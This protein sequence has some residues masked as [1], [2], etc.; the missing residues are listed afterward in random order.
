MF[1]HIFKAVSNQIPK[2]QLLRTKKRKSP[3][4]PNNSRTSKSY[5]RF[6]VITVLFFFLSTI[7]YSSI[8]Y[9]N[10]GQEQYI[11]DEY[12]NDIIEENDDF[13]NTIDGFS[14]DKLDFKLEIG[15]ELAPIAPEAGDHEQ[16]LE[17]P[18]SNGIPVLTTRYKDP[19]YLMSNTRGSGPNVINET[20]LLILVKFSDV[21]TTRPVSEL[22]DAVFNNTPSAISVH[23]YYKEVSYGIVNIEPGAQNGAAAGKWLNISSNRTF[24]G[25][26]K[27]SGSYVTDDG[28]SLDGKWWTEGKVQLVKDACN[29]TDAAGVDFKKY[30]NDGPDGVP[31]SADDDGVVDHVL[32]IFSGNGQNHYGRDTTPSPGPDDD[33]GINDYG[34]DLVW[35]SR[36]QYNFG[37]YDGK[38]VFGATVN[39]EDP[40]FNI[41][42][43]VICHEFGHDLGL[44]DLY[45]TDGTTNAVV[46]NWELM[47]SGTYNTNSTGAARPSHP[48]A[49][50]KEQLG[51]IQP[52]IINETNNNQGV[53]RVNQTTSPTNDSVC[54]KVNIIGENEYYL[55]E[56]RN[57]TVGTYEEGLSDRGILIWHID[58]DMNPYGNNRG[59]PTYTYYPILLE[60]YKND[61]NGENYITSMNTAC[62]KSSGAADQ[63][64]F[65]VSTF[66]NS[67]AN[68]G[69]RSGIYIDRIL[70]NSLWNMTVRILVSDDSNLPG[71]PRDVKVYDSENDNGGSINI[72]WNASLD[73]GTGDD[74]VVSYNILINETGSIQNPKRLIRVVD[75]IDAPDYDI[76]ITGLKDGVTYNFTVL[77]DDGPNV[78]PYPGNFTVVPLDNIALPP[79]DV[80]AVDTFPDDG[81]NITITWSLSD[82]DPNSIIPGAKDIIRYNISYGVIISGPK[83]IL[84][85]LGPGNTSFRVENLTNGVKYYFLVTAVDDVL[86]EG[87]SIEVNATPI[88]N[89]IGSPKNIQV[90]PSV[91]SNNSRYLIQWNNP[92]DNSQIAEAFYKIGSP[93]TSND[94]FTGNYSWYGIYWLW[95][96]DL[97]SDGTHTVYIWLKDYENNAD[98][99]TARF[100]TIRHDETPPASVKNL[101]VIPFGWSSS[102]SFTFTWTNPSEVSGVNGVHFTINTPPKS[103]MDGYYRSGLNINT[104]SNINISNKG[105]NTIYIWLMDRAYNSDYKTYTSIDFY[106]DPDEPNRPLNLLAIPSSWTNINS[107]DVTWDNPSEL[108]GIIGAWYKVGSVPTSNNDG[109]YKAG[110]NISRINKIKAQNTGSNIVYVWLV[111]NAT[112]LDY[113]LSNYTFLR[114][115]ALAPDRPV[116]I[117]SLPSFW[118][119]ENRFYINWSLPWEWDQSSIIGVY[120][121]FNN[122]PLHNTDGIFISSLSIKE[123]FNITVPRNG[124]NELYLWLQ[125]EVGNV[126][127]LNRTSF[128]LY[129]DA[130]APDEPN[131]LTPHPTNIW[132]NKNN[133]SVSWTNPDE[134]SGIAGAYYKVNS[135][136]NYN[137]DGIYIQRNWINHI[138]DIKVPKLG[139]NTIY[140]WLVDR[141]GNINYLNHSYVKLLFDD[142]PPGPPINITVTPSKWTRNN[143]FN[144]SWTN[145]EEHSGIYGLYYWFSAP[146]QNIGSL[147]IK[148]GINF[149]PNFKIP[150]DDPPS[151]EYTLYIWLIDNAYNFDFR[152]NNSQELLY[153][154]SA[155]YITHTRVYYATRD[156]PI[157]I[158]TIVDDENS[159]VNEVKIHYKKDTDKDY[160]ELVMARSGSNIYKGEIPSNKVTGNSLSYFISASDNT[161]ISNI[162]YYGKEGQVYYKPDPNSD[163]DIQILDED[164]IPPTIMHQR[165][166]KGI[167][168]TKLA[169][170][171]TVTDD[172]SGVKDVKVFYKI[173]T[174]RN[175]QE[176]N[177][178]NGNPYYYE[179]PESVMTSYGVDYY[180]YAIDNSPKG[181]EIYFGNYGLTTVRP[182]TNDSYI[183]IIVSSL[184]DIAP[185]II[186]GPEV[187]D[188]KSTTANVF[189]ITDEPSDSVIEFDTDTELSNRGFNTSYVTSHSLFLTGLTP[190]TL[191]Y[192]QVS[193]KDRLGNG[194]TFS[195]VFTF[196]TTKVG[197]EDTDGD[198]LPDNVDTDDDNDK[199]PD[200]VF[201]RR[202]AVH[203]FLPL[204]QRTG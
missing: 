96:E 188:V 7:F 120:Y 2:R 166:E 196:R 36:L 28:W 75:A 30:D 160:T 55:V 145:P 95:V 64:D 169:M 175:F 177:M 108:S 182:N 176:A 107:F 92:V 46:G 100:V 5:S 121:K 85:T 84:A 114:Y 59:P 4:N 152:N 185:L 94:D 110:K 172:G 141:V 153:D 23:N 97:L 142:Q 8:Y 33:G 189:W 105:K 140:V 76:Q 129:Y 43:G 52:I 101:A 71:P 14:I 66:P 89:Y 109:T 93:P 102:Y 98:Y 148:D 183:Q 103:E 131:L 184:D 134:Y 144:I 61:A 113:R 60:N 128:T 154:V 57:K 167:V 99:K 136:P 44:P 195:N 104:L 124:T 50:C 127:Y 198:N 178:K 65:N 40:N 32:I 117:Q 126:D 39:P 180:L 42:V 56:N 82:D 47:D 137:T 190:D 192:Y 12:Q 168:G 146:T 174:D 26:D 51:W 68:G 78:S 48:G 123:L 17:K 106:Y 151:D 54:Y 133:F 112:N 164:V 165:I 81:M 35:P 31:N 191:Y 162:R 139:E 27:T 34:R 90:S 119:N 138:D 161:D 150:G 38:N 49:W 115:D 111:D 80:A 187:K 67:S 13:T 149:I 163:I 170:T 194:P 143:D 171:A 181:N 41:P 179:L 74:D 173:R 155:P 73:D 72:S 63:A 204:T 122:P 157:T 22:E 6:I 199:I 18:H 202:I 193:S 45:D 186:F 21:N 70:D 83:T 58:D 86:N 88:D 91:W 158:T 147:I 24:Y 25:R 15:Y 159:G 201:L 135:P 1:P 19:D 118:T 62:W 9:N 116:N 132:T 200:N 77:S 37:Q 203:H 197:E 125:D 11:D 3:N 79:L 87:R 29:A 10:F 16:P 130:L 53:V 20:V 69:V 156:F